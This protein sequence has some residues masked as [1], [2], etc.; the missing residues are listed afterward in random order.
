MAPAREIWVTP[1]SF[2]PDVTE[3]DYMSHE[4]DQRVHSYFPSYFETQ[5]SFDVDSDIPGPRPANLNEERST[6]A[7][8][9][10]QEFLVAHKDNIMMEMAIAEKMG[11]GA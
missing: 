10:L 5:V 7:S 3:F 6:V 9:A 11:G 2:E 1:T 8:M 4:L